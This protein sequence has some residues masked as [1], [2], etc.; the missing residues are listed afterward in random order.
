M[1]KINL[2]VLLIA[3]SFLNFSCKKAAYKVKKE[4]IESMLE[5]PKG[6]KKVAGFEAVKIGKKIW[7]T[8]NFNTVS[9]RNGDKI[10]ESKNAQE[11]VEYLRAGK[12]TYCNFNFKSENSGK[13]GKIYN[14]Y[15]ITDNR[16]LA[17][18]GWHISKKNE[19][20]LL[21]DKFESSPLDLMSKIGW[22][23][24]I[25]NNNSGF[26]AMSCDILYYGA[27][28]SPNGGI[29]CTAGEFLEGIRTYWCFQA[30]ENPIKIGGFICLDKDKLWIQED[31]FSQDMDGGY[32]VRCVRD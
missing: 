16:E 23:E 6:I 4:E 26:N 5:G 8:K 1:K 32:Y 7:M 9:F 3:L 22:S 15:A 19:W 11:W 30:G 17:P 14:S 29:S 2:L 10:P 12:P 31:S 20:K 24:N 27:V 28:C 21:I 13:Y 18:K 25:G